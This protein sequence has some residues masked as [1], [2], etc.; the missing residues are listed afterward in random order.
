[1]SEHSAADRRQSEHLAMT[2]IVLRPTGNPLPLAFMALAVATV[3]F[4]SVQLGVVGPGEEKTIALGVLVLTVPLQ[5]FSSVLG[6]GARDPIAGTGMAMVSGVWALL[7]T[8]TL[9]SPPDT[10]S[11]AVGVMLLTAAVAILVPAAAAHGKLVAGAVLAGSAVRFATT[12]MAELTGSSGWETA[13]GALGILLALLALYAAF[14]FEQ[15]EVEGRMRLPLLRRG[16]GAKPLHDDMEEQV[17]GIAKEAGV[18][19]QL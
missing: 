7:A 13:A 10:S 15:E 2:R 4:S 14:G 6:F 9:T 3:G 1:M 16:A 8:S 18:R 11:R 17:E 19:H 12:G 5:A